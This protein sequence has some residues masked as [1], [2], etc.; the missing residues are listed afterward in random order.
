MLFGFLF[1]TVRAT[2][3]AAPTELEEIQTKVEDD[4]PKEANL[5]NDELGD[6]D[7][8]KM[9]SY[10]SNREATVSVPGPVDPTEEVGIKDSTETTKLNVPP[11]PGLGNGQG[12]GLEAPKLGTLTP[13]GLPGGLRGIYAPGGIGGRSGATRDALVREGGGNTRS[14]AAVA[15]GIKWLVQHQA[16]DGHWSLDGFNQ[17]GHCNCNGFGQNNDTAATAFGLLPLLGAGE[18]HK[19]TKGTYTKQVDRALKYLI[20]KQGRDGNFGGTMY[21]HG[22]ATIA[23]C[24]AYG[25]TADPRLKTPAQAAINFIRAAQ[26]DNGGW[27][28]EP[29]Q[30][31]DTSVVGWQLMALKSGQMAGLDVDDAKNP[32]FAKATRWLNSCMSSDGGYGYQG[33]EKTPTM[34]AVGLLCRL[35]LGT[36]PRN[37]GIR[38][39]VQYLRDPGNLPGKISSIYYYYYAT[40]VMHHV[41]GSVWEEWN[42]KMRDYLIDKQDQGSTK[43]RPHLRGSWTPAGDAH[44]GAGGRLMTTSLSLLTLEVY[45]R[46]LPLYR[47]DRAMASN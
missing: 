13:I 29:R 5:T 16:P 43:G 18:T 21:G 28:Y 30:G 35:Y 40:Q 11:P 37:T 15:S 7:P 4:K 22:L 44:G 47:R 38:S 14:E 9:L 2:G 24:E 26:S 10:E 6:L 34:T 19:N 17:H 42:P 12:G 23:I 25:M 27:R 3:A 39:G 20:S 8:D 41:G 36:G 1:V 33:P 45:Y 31:G 32:T 46:H